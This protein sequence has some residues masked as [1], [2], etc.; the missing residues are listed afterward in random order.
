MARRGSVLV[1]ALGFLAMVTVM[2]AGIRTALSTQTRLMR[3][4]RAQMH[5]MSWARAGVYLAM[6]RLVEEASRPK[7][8]VERLGAAPPVW[9]AVIPA[10][11]N[12]A[13]G[14]SGV[15]RVEIIDDARKLNLNTAAVGELER[16]VGDSALARAIVASRALRPIRRLEAL[17]DLPE[18]S[19][20]PE[21]QRLILDQTTVWTGAVRIRAVGRIDHPAVGYHIEAVVRRGGGGD[22]R[23][24]QIVEW[25][26]GGPWSG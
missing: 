15:I 18:M 25:N 8:R 2:A 19:R 7:E 23:A 12:D 17:W 13:A 24:F 26:E 10:G 11:T 9:E 21:P 6:Q 20:Q 22:L 5:A 3:Y 1:V 14:L 16:A 4:R